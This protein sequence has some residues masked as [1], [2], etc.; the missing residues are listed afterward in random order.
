MR[1]KNKISFSVKLFR[2]SQI[3]ITKYSCFRLICR[4]SLEKIAKS[5]CYVVKNPKLLN[6]FPCITFFSNSK[7]DNNLHYVSVFLGKKR[8]SCFITWGAT[9]TIRQRFLIPPILVSVQ[10]IFFLFLLVQNTRK[11]LQS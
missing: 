9:F 4:E 3:S 1:E 8:F 2:V 11:D 5:L 6:I 7:R 10:V